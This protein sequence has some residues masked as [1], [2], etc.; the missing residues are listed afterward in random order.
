MKQRI[1]SAIQ[2]SGVIH[3]GNY[4]GALKNWI[5]LQKTYDALFC[6]VD[7]HAITVKQ[8]PKAL[9]AKIRELAKLYIA[10]GINPETIFVQSR[11]PEHAELAWILNTVTKV[12]EL[13]RM[14][15]YKDK[16]SRHAANINAG[17]FCYPVLMAADILL[18]QTDLVPVGDDQTQHLELARTVAKRFNAQFG[19][20]FRVPEGYFPK[21]G[22]RILSLDDPT[23][24]MSKSGAPASFISLLDDESTI[25]KKIARAVTDSGS[26]I[27]ARSDKPALTNLLT[28]H[29]LLS[30]MSLAD[31][32][33]RYIGK[34]Y[35]E[36]KADL[37]DVI[38]AF[39]QPIQ[40]RYA[41]LSDR[42]IETALNNGREKARAI[43][44]ETLADVQRTIGLG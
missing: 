21:S 12:A 24:K 5:E 37:A 2:P 29:H 13:E 6:I 42:A 19:D 11:V 41:A 38:A 14:T 16:A 44:S 32:E 40:E 36:F 9:H 10:V 22:A 26:D 18:Y 31:L 39:L 3:I 28:I 1:F 35:K 27:R 43:A 34:G 33:K 20:V 25:H 30:G 15:Q 17:L 4:L 7:L 8:D 23:A